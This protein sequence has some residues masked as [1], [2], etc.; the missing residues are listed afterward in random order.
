M[1][2]FFFLSLSSMLTAQ[3][4]PRS[5]ML[6]TFNLEQQPDGG[7]SLG[8]TGGTVTIFQWTPKWV[9]F[10]IPIA[11][12][13]SRVLVSQC[14]FSWPPP[15]RCGGKHLFSSITNNP[16]IVILGQASFILK[17]LPYTIPYAEQLPEK[18]HWIVAK[19]SENVGVAAHV[20]EGSAHKVALVF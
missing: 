1:G 17:R 5:G 19:L 14:L 18:L 16:G 13:P 6:N 10:D 8:G 3:K 20:E 2:G 15:R 7:G 12:S 9:C 11:A 4:H